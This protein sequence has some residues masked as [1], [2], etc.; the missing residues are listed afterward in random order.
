MAL[1]ELEEAKEFL[2]V[3]ID[4]DDSKLQELLDAALDEAAQ[5]MG[6]DSIEDFQD[7]LDSSDCLLDNPPASVKTAIKLLLQADYQTPVNEI[8]PLK[9]A[10]LRKLN[11][12]RISWGV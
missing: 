11:P 7:Y 10:A 6:Y 12:F 2:D 8:E 3:F 1:V 5:Y 9:N 4:S